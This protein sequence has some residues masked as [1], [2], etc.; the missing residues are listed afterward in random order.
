MKT[1]NIINLTKFSIVTLLLSLFFISC[2]N[3]DNPPEQFTNDT[4]AHATELTVGTNFDAHAVQSTTVD[5]THTEGV[6]TD[7]DCG[8][9]PNAPEVWFTAT[10]PESGALFIETKRFEQ[11][12]FTDTVINYYESCDMSTYISCDDD[13]D[14]GYTDIGNFS[15]LP[16]YN[17]TPGDQVFVAVFGYDSSDKGDFLIAAI[18]FS[19]EELLSR[20]G[21]W[22]GVTQEVYTNNVLTNTVD[23]TNQELELLTNH[24]FKSYVNSAVDETGN[25]S[26]IDNEETLN[27]FSQDFTINELTSSKLVFTLHTTVGG[28]TTDV[29]FTYNK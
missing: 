14:N 16:I 4:C 15:K 26:L 13:N 6:I 3:D 10:V 23:V 11:S 25:W 20:T 18:D 19:K 29:V 7:D 22:K 1:L 5:A 24:T 2:K 8:G 21:R 12:L 27:L 9:D 28:D 17:K